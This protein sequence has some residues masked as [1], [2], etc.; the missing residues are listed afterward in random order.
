LALGMNRA[1]KNSQNRSLT[2]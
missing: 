1:R 2:S